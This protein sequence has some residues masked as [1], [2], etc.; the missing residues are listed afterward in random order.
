MAELHRGVL[1][2]QNSAALALR[3]EAPEAPRARA[4]A[5]ARVA[6]VLLV[7]AQAH[8][9]SISVDDIETWAGDLRSDDSE[10]RRN[11]I[12]RLSNMPESALP[13]IDE[14]IARTR[15][16]I[17]DA[18]DG[19]DA[20]RNFRHATGSLRADDMVDIA[21][22]IPQTLAERRNRTY[23]R[24]AERVLIIRSLERMGTVDAQRRIADVFG[25]TNEMWK[26][27]ARR[28]VQ[29]MGM[30][31]LP[32]LI[33]ARGHDDRG[34]RE[35]A[36]GHIDR[37]GMK[38]PAD[39]LT[40]EDPQLLAQVIEAY[41]E[42]RDLDTM[43]VIISYVGHEHPR[44]REAARKA[45]ETFG[46]NG[47]WQLREGMRNQLGQ[48]ADA[49]WG[50][51][52]TMQELYEGL[53]EQR[54]APFA[55]R[56]DEALKLVDEGDYEV[57]RMELDRLLL[58]VAQPPRSGD[59][60]AAYATLAEAM[61][62]PSLFRRAAWLA[63][64]HP[65]AAGWRAHLELLEAESLREEG[66]VDPEAYRQ[67][68]QHDNSD[69]ARAAAEEVLGS[70]ET[71]ELAAP[72][73][74]ESS[75]WMWLVGLLAL[76]A[77]GA[78]VAFKRGDIRIPQR[79]VGLKLRG[80]PTLRSRKAAAEPA[81]A[82]DAQM[83]FGPTDAH[84]TQ[85]LVD[86]RPD[87]PADDPDTQPDVSMESSATDVVDDPDTE[88]GL[89]EVDETDAPLAALMFGAPSATL[90]VDPMTMDPRDVDTLPGAPAP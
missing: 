57:A 6:L 15:R 78:G 77:I 88:P 50:W 3:R 61:E 90:K 30:S 74:E 18:E 5:L 53:D 75:A 4:H 85:P 42:I 23:G 59:V 9:Q 36:R 79:L 16:Q 87:A 68:L 56:V 52:R 72:V 19:Y 71:E 8:A 66:F 73:P 45:F 33:L 11:A 40:L 37:L 86:V 28:I 38:N 14:R 65:E 64:D 63:P 54:L 48:R 39:A 67:V 76:A 82:I 51:R 2:F 49:R 83:I 47:I 1:G 20:L 69:E 22:G 31:L 84:D 17:I 44:V 12:E 81:R 60:A 10:V 41:T 55:G 26:W 35:W 7:T 80:L 46:R 21:E 62:D 70:E 43:P 13:A 32:G 58:E 89:A 27:E 29:R 24:T 34:V 25:L